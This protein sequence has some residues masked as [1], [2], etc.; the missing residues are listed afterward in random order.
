MRGCVTA[1][2]D[3]P[4]TRSAM[5]RLRS[6]RVPGT[7]AGLFRRCSS[8]CTRRRAGPC[9]PARETERGQPADFLCCQLS[10]III[11]FFL[12]VMVGARTDGVGGDGKIPP[13]ISGSRFSGRPGTEKFLL[14]Y[15]GAR[16]RRWKENM[17]QNGAVVVVV[18]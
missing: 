15:V 6:R 4:S 10:I 14:C 8:G 7:L 17:D 18:S 3:V 13:F 16:K 9:K 1:V 12:A 2:E 5:C 11:I